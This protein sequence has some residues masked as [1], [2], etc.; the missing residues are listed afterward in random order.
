MVIEAHILQEP[1]VRA[2][3]QFAVIR[4]QAQLASLSLQRDQ[5]RREQKQLAR[6]PVHGFA[7]GARFTR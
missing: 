2:F 3:Q 4:E 5:L 1:A 6:R 7:A